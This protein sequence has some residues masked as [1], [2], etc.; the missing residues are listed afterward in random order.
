SD[1]T[2]VL[3]LCRTDGEQHRFATVLDEAGGVERV[4]VAVGSIARGFRYPA[5]QLVVVDHHELVGLVGAR[6]V[7]PAKQAYRTR[8]LQSFF[9]LKP[10]DFVVHAVHG[11]ALY[12][13]LERMTRG[14]GEEEH[15]HLSF[16]DEVSLFVPATRIDLVQ[17][18]IGSGGAAPALDKIGGQSFRK[19]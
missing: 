4:D 18:Y 11:L 2:R 10:G 7:A 1:G 17:R 8:A 15:L 5:L 12:K 16:A 9:D 6:R 19:R 3:V 13:G 14:G